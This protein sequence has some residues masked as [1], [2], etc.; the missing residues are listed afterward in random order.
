MTL[1]GRYYDYPH[2]NDEEDETKHLVKWL[3][4]DHTANKYWRWSLISDGMTPSLTLTLFDRML[5][6]SVS[7]SAALLLPP[8]PHSC[9]DPSVHWS[10]PL[11]YPDCPAQGTTHSKW[12]VL[13][14][15]EVAPW[16]SSSCHSHWLIW[17][18]YANSSWRRIKSTRRKKRSPSYMSLLT[19]K[20]SHRCHLS[21]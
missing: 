7:V 1:W 12:Q 16:G 3:D 9:W 20:F 21:I 14:Q 17:N 4:Q 19:Q 18:L 10:S 15:W 2:F 13:N 6:W 5:S 8:W 11:A